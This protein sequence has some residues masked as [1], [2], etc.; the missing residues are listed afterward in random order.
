MYVCMHVC[1]YVQMDLALI[2]R[3]RALEL[4]T[5]WRDNGNLT[6]SMYVFFYVINTRVWNL[7]ANL[8]PPDRLFNRERICV[9]IS[10]DNRRSTLYL[11]RFQSYSISVSPAKLKLAKHEHKEML[12]A[13]LFHFVR[14][15][16]FRNILGIYFRYHSESLRSCPVASTSRKE[17]AYDDACYNL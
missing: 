11:R 15:V 16:Y 3:D 13:S 6:A 12:V 4:H 8:I 5:R 7:F 2:A 10:S 9:P 1:M 17:N 14:Q